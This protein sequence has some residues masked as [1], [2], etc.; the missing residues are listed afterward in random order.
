LVSYFELLKPILIL[1]VFT[2]VAG[3]V[4]APGSKDVITAI[5]TIIC[6]TTGAGASAS[7]NMWYDADI[8]ALMVRTARRPIPTG[9]VSPRQGLVFG[10]IL[11]VVNQLVC[12]LPTCANHHFLRGS[13]H[14]VAEA[15]DAPKY[16]NWRRSGRSPT[17]DL[18]CGDGKH[19]PRQLCA[20]SDHLLLDTPALLG[21]RPFFN[22]RLRSGG[23]TDDAKRRRASFDEAADGDVCELDRCG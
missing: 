23:S 14:H 11:S 1:V 15:L 3:F 17:D 7:L 19:F 10:I 6:V 4:L 5:V 13:I 22:T 9:R 18:V 2:A 16:R 8:D 20:I 12:G 21:T